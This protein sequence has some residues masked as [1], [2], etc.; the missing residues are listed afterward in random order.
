M[1]KL[2]AERRGESILI[3]YLPR[4]QKEYD[5]WMNGI[6]ELNPERRFINRVALLPD[7]SILNHYWDENETPRP[8]SFKEDVEL[9]EEAN[10]QKHN[11]QE[12]P[13]SGRIRLGF[14]FTL[15]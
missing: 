8:E 14:F 2:L 6:E 4:L 3:E 5:F 1:V 13:G 7:G 10:V 9:A 12:S 15:V 11:V